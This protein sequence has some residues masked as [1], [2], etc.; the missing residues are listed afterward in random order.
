MFSKRLLPIL[1]TVSTANV[2]A[3]V[4]NID[5]SN[6]SEKALIKHFESAKKNSYSESIKELSGMFLGQN[7]KSDRLIG[8][9][10]SDERLVID[11]SKLDCFTYIDYVESLRLSNSIHSFISNLIQTRY[12]E[13]RIHYLSRRHFFS[14]WLSKNENIE[15][16]TDKITSRHKSL[17]KFINLKADGKKFIPGLDI[18]SRTIKFI[19]SSEID[20]SVI[21][22]LKT[23][24]YI[25][26]FTNIDGLDVT[27]T[28]IFIRNGDEI[29][30][31][32]ASSSYNVQMVIDSPFQNYV[33]GVPG[34]IVYR[35]I[36]K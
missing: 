15:D 33:S 7:Y 25:G 6:I 14:D 21:S 26:I 22:K 32:H 29:F 11:F 24:D 16:I 12:F 13:G 20:P 28:G 10:Q 18:T 2:Y 8:S 9:A 27:H 19:P 34:I 31:R 17:V 23:G 4:D 36:H 1:V 30:L 5:F 3:E 35:P